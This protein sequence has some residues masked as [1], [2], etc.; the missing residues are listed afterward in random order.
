MHFTPHPL[1]F[2][3]VEFILHGGFEHQF[4]L[5]RQEKRESKCSALHVGIN[6]LFM[7]EDGW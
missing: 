2:K 4:F 5:F 3:K 7:Q 1:F 6:S